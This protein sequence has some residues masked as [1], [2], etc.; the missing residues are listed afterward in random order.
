MPRTCA[1]LLLLALSWAFPAQGQGNFPYAIQ[2]VAG[3]EPLGDGG[4][5]LSAL[6]ESPL[7]VTV[8]GAGN[9]YLSEGGSPRIRLV[10]P[11]GVIST[12]KQ[13]H[14]ADVKVDA[15]GNVYASDQS[16]QVFKISRSGVSTVFAG[17]S[18]GPPNGDG[19]PAV[20]SALN[21]PQG[22]ALD[23]AGNVYIADTLNNRVCKVTTDGVLHNF[24][25]NGTAIS[26]GDGSPAT[27]AQLNNPTSVAV[28]SQ[29]NVYIADLYIVGHNR[30]RKV[31][32][33]NGII[34]TVVGGGTLLADGPG[35]SAELGSALG[36]AVDANDNLLIADGQSDRIRSWDPNPTPQHSPG[37]IQTVAGM[38]GS[39][40][41]S[42]DNGPATSAQLDFPVAVSVDA[43]GNIY[44]ADN[45]N[46]RIRKMDSTDTITTVAG[47]TPFGG[48]GADALSALLNLPEH[49]IMD[50]AGNLYI[51]DSENNRIRQVTPGGAIN[52]YAGTG[53][54][55]YNGDN[56]P[57]T[58]A[59]LCNPRALAFDAGGNL[60]VADSGNGRVRRITG[61]PS[62]RLLAARTP[63]MRATL[64]R[65]PRRNFRFR[66]AWRLTARGTCTSRT[67]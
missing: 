22:L 42:G 51:S 52:T 35:L 40:G 23:S 27:A 49:A 55:A 28:D 36:L 20:Q 29:G 60:Y 3:S 43:A 65:R 62:A 45:V 13:M 61:A 30:I 24:A 7:A 17:A 50:S 66:S 64:G 8:D 34:T 32:A 53:A 63:A 38:S 16:H 33:S 39:A 12:F 67:K 37:W 26:G 14:A 47:R 57:A 21:H 31:A 15:A 5:A 54:C 25:G 11:G 18:V 6:L 44:I 2:T 10:T 4:P 1:A 58:S 9:I 56:R 48:D 59:S 19:I 46:Q 41:F